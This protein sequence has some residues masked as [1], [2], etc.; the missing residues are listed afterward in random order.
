MV[1]RVFFFLSR[2]AC[3]L[4]LQSL[5]NLL[6]RGL[7]KN[8]LH[9]TRDSSMISKNT[10]SDSPQSGK[11]VAVSRINKQTDRQTDRHLK[12]L[13]LHSFCRLG[14]QM[15]ENDALKE[16]LNSTLKAKE[17]DQSCIKN[18]Q[19]RPRT[20]FPVGTATIQTRLCTKLAAVAFDTFISERLSNERQRPSATILPSLRNLHYT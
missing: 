14:I 8:T 2:F 17:E 15:D 4:E 19:N 20:N 18:Q 13:R 16:A 7:S 12:G 1:Y 6:C 10:N 9:S 5:L 11:S 3:F